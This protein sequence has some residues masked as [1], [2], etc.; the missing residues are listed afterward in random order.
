MEWIRLFCCVAPLL[1]LVALSNGTLYSS[2]LL[3]G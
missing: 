1:L 3:S 2:S